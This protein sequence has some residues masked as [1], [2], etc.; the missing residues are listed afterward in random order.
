PP[1]PHPSPRGARSIR[2]GP[3]R[4]KRAGGMSRA[5]RGRDRCTRARH[6][7]HTRNEG[8]AMAKKGVF[9]VMAKVEPKQEAAFN[10]WSD[11]DHMP[12]ALNR[13]PGVLTGRRYKIHEG[14]DGFNYMAM[15]EFD[16]YEHVA[17]TLQSDIIKGLIKEFDDAFPG[18]TRKRVTATQIKALLGG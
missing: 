16:S 5:S 6:Q 10:T 12:K 13:F 2:A 4:G 8:A 1:V 18:V 17:E 7:Q 14:G 11:E 9:I 15:Y 3:G